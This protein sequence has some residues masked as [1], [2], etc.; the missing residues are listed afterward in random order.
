MHGI[1]D[2]LGNFAW[3]SRHPR[4]FCVQDATFPDL[5]G[6]SAFPGG[7]PFFL[8]KMVPLF[9]LGCQIACDTGS[10]LIS[11]S[12]YLTWE[13]AAESNSW[14]RVEREGQFK[15]KWAESSGAV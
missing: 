11:G 1:P 3:D 9:F 7:V 6:G 12:S 2:I 13:G 14:R 8:G 4:K 10:K 15:M 5:E